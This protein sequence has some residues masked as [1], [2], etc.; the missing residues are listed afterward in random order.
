MKS[1]IKQ[2]IF[3]L[4]ALGLFAACS[5]DANEP[6]LDNEEVTEGIELV[7]PAHFFGTRADA[8][9]N[10]FTED[11]A[12]INTLYVLAYNTEATTDAAKKPIVQDLSSAIGTNVS[13]YMD[14]E[15]KS[16]PCRLPK[17][18]Y[19]IYLIANVNNGDLIKKDDNAGSQFEDLLETDLQSAELR[20]MSMVQDENLKG[21][22]RQY[23]PMS[24]YYTE[25]RKSKDAETEFAN[26]IVEIK[27]AEKKTVYADL[28][29]A[30]SKIRITIFNTKTQGMALDDTDI[31]STVTS[32]GISLGNISTKE[33]AFNFNHIEAATSVTT[34]FPTGT[35]YKLPSTWTSD[36]TDWSNADVV[37]N[38]D[39]IART[40]AMSSG[41]K[42]W[43][44]Q[45]IVYVP[46]RIYGGKSQDT[47]KSNITIKFSNGTNSG[48][49]ILNGTV[50]G[51]TIKG[52]ERGKLY[53]VIGYVDAKTVTLMVR[54][55]PWQYVK[56]TYDLEDDDAGSVTP[57]S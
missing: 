19:H 6:A 22:S 7:I 46:E 31:N 43:K 37:T 57:V 34:G 14:P 41:T 3:A 40:N 11:E 17:G 53:D 18:K 48:A 25:L 39:A 51:E 5:S 55:K 8:K 12:K 54:V 33:T 20:G 27:S 10:D 28:I 13:A 1:Y 29:F 4:A 35:Y 21:T 47:D 9:I 23:L 56:Y 44:W 45:S 52:F 42:A 2:S 50:N 16:V 30:V 26:G 38:G 36:P 49:K 32:G 24:T 15:Y